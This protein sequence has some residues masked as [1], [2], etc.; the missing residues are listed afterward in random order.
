MSISTI[1]TE[2]EILKISSSNMNSTIL[3]FNNLFSRLL[4]AISA[5]IF[6]YYL[7]ILNLQKT[8]LWMGIILILTIPIF[9]YWFIRIIKSNKG[10]KEKLK[11]T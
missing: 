9:T 1:I 10:I 2:H 3:S 8:M 4:F 7:E 11:N 6:G 5:P